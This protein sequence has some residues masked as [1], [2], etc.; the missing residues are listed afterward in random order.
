MENTNSTD[1]SIQ[2]SSCGPQPC[3]SGARIPKN[4]QKSKPIEKTSEIKEQDNISPYLERR[5]G[6]VNLIEVE[7]IDYPPSV[8]P[9]WNNMND[10]IFQ[11]DI[12]INSSS[13]NSSKKENKKKKNLI[14]L[15]RLQINPLRRVVKQIQ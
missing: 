5:T 6:I 7:P 1:G 15:K 9:P 14:L 10:I 13:S 11:S 8:P 3:S 2:H 4:L 12:T